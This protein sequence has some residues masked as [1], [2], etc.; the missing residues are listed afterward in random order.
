[1]SAPSP[2]VSARRK[3][4]RGWRLFRVCFRWTRITFLLLIL[5]VV[6]LGLF[7]NHVGLPEVV[8]Q[9]V[10]DQLR[11]Q[12]WDVEFSRLRL[13]WYRGLVADGVH[14]R[15]ADAP[16]G[17]QLFIEEAEGRLNFR[18]LR[19]LNL[20]VTGVILREG[21]LL[22]PLTATNRPRQ[23]FCLNELHGEVRFLPGDVWDLPGAR[24][25]CLGAKLQL[26]GLVTNASAL[27]HWRL[28]R[29]ATMP[30]EVQRTWPSDLWRELRRVHFS[31]P[32]QVSGQ[33]A[34]DARDTNSL[35]F[36]LRLTAA[37]VGSPWGRGTNL[38]SRLRLSPPRRPSAPF[39][40]SWFVRA[41]GLRTTWGQ[42]AR[43]EA[44]THLEPPSGLFFPPNAGFTLDLTAPNTR[45]GQAKRVSFQ[46]KMTS[47]ERGA[48]RLTSVQ[49]TAQGLHTPW[50]ALG[51]AE[52]HGR[53]DHAAT[54]L[55]PATFTLDLDAR[56]VR[57]TNNQA[58]SAQVRAAGALPTADQFW[59]FRTNL[60]WPER[61]EHLPLRA[62]LVL[63]NLTTPAMPLARLAVTGDWRAPRLAA[64][65]DAALDNGTA[66]IRAHLNSITRE[67]QMQAR[68]QFDPARLSHL[69]GTDAQEALRAF[70]WETP[71]RLEASAD[72]VLPDWARRA[73]D[74]RAEVLPTLSLHGLLELGAGAYQGVEFTSA[75]SPFAYA[76]HVWQLLHLDLLRPEGALSGAFTANTLTH[77]FSARLH[78]TLDPHLI[79]PWLQN[80]QARELLDEF[81]LTAPPVIAARVS[82]NWRDG[83]RL[84]VQADCAA[85]NF[86]FRREPIKDCVTGLGFTNQFLRFL[87]PQIRREGEI[88]RADGVGVDLR[89]QVVHLTNAVGNL[90]PYAIARVIGPHVVTA[91]EPYQFEHSP[92]GRVWGAI[93]M[94]ASGQHNDAH[95]ELSGGPFRWRDFALPEIAGHVHWLGQTVAVTN[96]HGAFYDGR[97]AGHLRVDFAPTHGDVFAFQ[98]LLTNVS[99]PGLV[100]AVRGKTNQLEGRLNG[101]LTVFHAN[102]ADPLSWQG[103]GSVN[104]TNGLLW[105]LP[106]FG[107]FSPVLNAFVPGLGNS[108]ARRAAATFTLANSV[109]HSRDLQIDAT[110][111]RM[112]YDLRVDFEQ[113]IEGR[114][115]AELL[116]NLPGLGLVLSK[117]LWP[118]TKLFEYRLSGTLSQPKTSPV[119]FIPRIL[120]LP[121]RPLKTI[122][123]LLPAEPKPEA[124]PKP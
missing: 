17:P 108:R 60:L 94:R 100:G 38:H 26:S 29:P 42:A 77:D 119:F 106:I 58:Q 35:A 110:A 97:I 36:V 24:A 10:V 99:L 71:P 118:V 74:W 109:I 70:S 88:G 113:R 87:N 65:V 98:M 54:N 124:P 69:L 9:R 7:L 114:V 68:A 12:G 49:A 34:L 92:T 93:D 121:F 115:E 120:L 104:L 22:L 105:D 78:S 18:A 53:L 112:Q 89:A 23:M 84:D 50:A 19:R 48:P 45:W 117:V 91:L 75:R 72:L 32:P 40:L 67:L 82:G 95:F 56:S 4:A 3:P 73:P 96:L 80:E 111:M 102:T 30:S 64:E 13:R 61:V 52:V 79:K 59:L 47:P 55:L 44:E 39:H 37:D 62:S 116:R 85:T 33:F 6:G 122:E 43:L 83:T 103:H 20:D 27:R 11:R 2:E 46:A 107:V 86:V 101:E 31:Q 66:W 15:R 63:S 90:S 1:V 51:Q 21:R 25:T 76:N 16:D 81:R 123:E 8:K 57:T 28:P 41:D 5:F 14:I